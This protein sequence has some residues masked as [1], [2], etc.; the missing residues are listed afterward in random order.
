M[1]I[2]QLKKQHRQNLPFGAVWLVT[3]VLD[4]VTTVLNNEVLFFHLCENLAGSLVTE[5]HSLDVVVVTVVTETVVEMSRCTA[6][7]HAHKCAKKI[8]TH[9]PYDLIQ[10]A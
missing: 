9:I 5:G 10:Y 1:V 7:A 4:C 2:S 8:H 3:G 6:N